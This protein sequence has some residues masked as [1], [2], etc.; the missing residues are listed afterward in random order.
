MREI[1]KIKISNFKYRLTQEVKNELTKQAKNCVVTQEFLNGCIPFNSICAK[2]I[3]LDSDL[4]AEIEL[5]NSPAGDR[6]LHN[7]DNESSNIRF[8]FILFGKIMDNAMPFNID[9]SSVKLLTIL[10]SPK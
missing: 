8:D 9:P 1:R 4:S 6:L 10:V 2:V 3:H 7:I 5:V